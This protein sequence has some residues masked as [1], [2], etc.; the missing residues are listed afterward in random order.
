MANI[1]GGTVIRCMGAN[2]GNDF[3]GLV[4]ETSLAE[5]VNGSGIFSVCS[6][7]KPTNQ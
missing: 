1:E 4:R 6:F 2:E 7:S 3:N 5:F